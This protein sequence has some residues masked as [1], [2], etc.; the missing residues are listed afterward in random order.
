MGLRPC[1]VW[2]LAALRRPKGTFLDVLLRSDQEIAKLRLVSPIPIAGDV[3]AVGVVIDAV[4]AS[5][6]HI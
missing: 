1:D 4:S 2:G 5:D 6:L 3:V